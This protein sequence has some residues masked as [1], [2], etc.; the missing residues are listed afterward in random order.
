[1]GS[2]S[3]HHSLRLLCPARP[4]VGVNAVGV[5]QEGVSFGGVNSRGARAGESPCQELAE[6]PAHF[7]GRGL[8]PAEEVMCF[9]H[10]TCM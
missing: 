3:Q 9:F 2:S 5:L 4:R 6:E 7:L 8:C 1:M 10:S